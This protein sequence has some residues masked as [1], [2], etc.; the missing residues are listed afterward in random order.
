MDL[1]KKSK[2]ANMTFHPYA[3]KE[4]KPKHIVAKRLPNLPANEII[5]DLQTQGIKCNKISIQKKKRNMEYP[6]MDPIYKLDFDKEVDMKK[7]WAIEYICHVK[8]KWEK[9]TEKDH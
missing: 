8:V 7:V 6:N 4:I 5:E 3:S 1:I 2:G 9:Y